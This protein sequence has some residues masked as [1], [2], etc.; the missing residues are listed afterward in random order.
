[1]M[2]K[3]LIFLILNFL[4]GFTQAKKIYIL[5]INK[6]EMPNDTNGAETIL[7]DENV[8]KEGDLSLKIKWISSGWV[9]D[10]QPKKA[11]WKGMKKLRCNIF[12]SSEKEKIMSFVIKDDKSEKDRNT[13]GIIFFKLKPGMNNVELDIENLKTK[14]NS[15]LINLGQIRQWHFSYCFFPEDE[16]EE[17]KFEEYTIYISNLRVESE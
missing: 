2:K 12:S 4:I 9:G 3:I 1:M 13:W 8:V 15:R 6:G 14:D 10:W 16:R 17:K 7:S 5:D 11:N